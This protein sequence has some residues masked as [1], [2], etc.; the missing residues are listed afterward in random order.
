[1][2]QTK[3]ITTYVCDLCAFEQDTDK[4]QNGTLEDRPD[5]WIS[6]AAKKTLKGSNSFSRDICPAC[7]FYIKAQL[8]RNS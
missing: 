7:L 3:S 4:H 5:G 8:E 6:I 2:N 1:M